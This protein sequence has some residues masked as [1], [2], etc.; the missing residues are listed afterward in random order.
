MLQFL[1]FTLLLVATTTL[2]ADLPPPSIWCAISP[3]PVLPAN[4]VAQANAEALRFF[5]PAAGTC[6]DGICDTSRLESCQSCPSDCGTCKVSAAVVKCTKP[7]VVAL[8]FD[9]G[10]SDFTRPLVD[11]LQR[12]N[13]KATFFVIGR[14]LL[15]ATH[16][17]ATR[18]AYSAGHTIGSHTFTHRSMATSQFDPADPEAPKARSPSKPLSLDA[19]RAEMIM[20]DLVIEAAIGV[21]PRLLRPPYLDTTR[22]ALA[23]LE[24]SGYVAVNINEDSNDW[25]LRDDPA[26][27]TNGNVLTQVRAAHTAA[28][29]AGSWILLQHDVYDYSTTAVASII[30]FYRSQGIKFVSV[31][32]CLGERPY[33]PRGM[34]S[35][36][37]LLDHSAY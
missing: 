8:T 17:A 32:E 9:D 18:Y 2:A 4:L 25:R 36:H 30:A 29:G 22:D 35:Q 6:G 5:G 1:Y 10:S 14:K 37:F 24:T 26:R 15:N 16:A 23:W 27:A 21:R 11:L 20:T 31:D 28:A 13:V 33:R 12:E 19:L 7:G 34:H 3:C